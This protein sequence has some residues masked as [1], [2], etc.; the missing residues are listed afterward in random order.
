MKQLNQSQHAAVHHTSGPLLILAGAGTGKTTVIT[1]K[2]AHLIESGQAKPEEILAL[3]FTDNAAAEMLERVEERLDLGYTDM[4]ISTF[5]AFCQR[6]LEEYGLDIG[7]PHQFKLFT[8]T[9]SWLL[10]RKHLYDFNLDYYRP[11]GNP[12]KHIK[13]LL[14]HFSACKDELIDPEKYL[15]YAEGLKLDND[16]PDEKTRLTELANGYHTYNQLLLDAGAMD[17][18]DLIRY[19][20]KLLEERRNIRK[21]LQAR[22]KYILVDEFQDV[23]WAQ[24]YLV[25]LLATKS[26]DP[27][28]H[29]ERSP[30]NAVEGSLV[31]TK[32]EGDPSTSSRL[33]R[34]SA[35]DDV[36][37]TVVGDDD[38]SIYAFRGASVSNIQ[39]FTDD[40]RDATTIV[41]NENYRSG[42]EILDIS[43]ASVKHND[44]DRLEAKLGIEKK[45]TAS[46][47]IKTADVK[48]LHLHT[49]DDEIFA[50]VEEIQALK[51][52]TGC[53]WDDIAIL[54]RAGA[55]ANPFMDALDKAQI[56]YEFLSSRGLYRE[57]IVM[58]AINFFRLLDTV[59]EST[60]IY[61][62]L[63]LPCFNV[64]RHDLQEFT[65]MAKKKRVSYFDLL[66]KTK[67]FYLPQSIQDVAEKITTLIKAGVEQTKHEKPT[68]ILVKFFQDSGYFDYIAREEG[69]GNAEVMHDVYQLKQFFS[70][71]EK[72]EEANPTA[73]VR[74][75][76]EHFEQVLE[77]GEQGSLYQSTDTPDSVNIMTV[78]GSKGL[79][80]RFVFIINMVDGRFPVQRR[81]G[82]I[83]VPDA[84]IHEIPPEGDA[85]YQE[86]RRLFYVA[87]TRAK[88]K[89]FFMSAEDYGGAR[90]KKI[91]RFLDELKDVMT[92]HTAPLTRTV[93]KAE[94]I[95]THKPETKAK[96]QYQLPSSFSI[97]QI[98]SFRRCP[99][100]YKL[101]HILKIPMAQSHHLSFGN[102][103]HN[104]L[105]A[106]YERVQALN[107]AKQVS[108]FS[109]YE[110]EPEGVTEVKQKEVKVP[111]LDELL[112]IYEQKWI[113]DWYESETQRKAR[114]EDGK[115]MLRD[116][117]R[118]RE[119]RWTVPITIEG[120]FRLRLG[121]HTIRGKID[122]IDQT[123]EGH[124]HIIDYKTGKP[125]DTVTGD[126]KDQLLLYQLAAETLPD[127]HHIGPVDRLSYY[128]LENDTA[129]SFKGEPKHLEKL[130]AKLV[131]TIEEILSTDWG[132][133]EKCEGSCFGCG[134][135]L[136]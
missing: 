108:L 95:R 106:F 99:Y 74:E 107:A 117:Y 35:Q 32:G 67:E 45:L 105:Q 8:E 134:D 52:K 71:L 41:L 43:Y 92:I 46:G 88:E 101:Q 104:T 127:Y 68:T 20:V 55:N 60:A 58:D 120:G 81:G 53:S 39:R 23:N 66:N 15:E 24:Y 115:R 65:H 135:T 47:D 102:S 123:A 56:P 96:I 86:E 83:D 49:L 136:I 38:Q 118:A 25:K 94:Y 77:S 5:H 9:D 70:Y 82:E 73:D 121:G 14:D 22:Y 85:H 48:H 6:V 97:S 34:D 63:R 119:G 91:S 129:V 79:E 69:Q 26:D 98:N 16:D 21:K 29:P 18:G 109:P 7:V 112:A 128:Y 3:T 27:L 13:A 131:Q 28:R 36:C 62:M 124:L 75:F 111:P 37:L 4:Q 12:S 125:K 42:Q 110:G 1:E 78:H 50:T 31:S 59:K 57:P 122:R 113:G 30:K 116:Y 114:K 84:L 51:D 11:I 76:M 103:M 2:I 19:S 33:S 100:Q 54:T 133:V 64:D 93:E 40:F 80:F 130:E 90:K 89:L 72:F 61:R 17:F 10:M 126:D 132:A 87:A 44:P